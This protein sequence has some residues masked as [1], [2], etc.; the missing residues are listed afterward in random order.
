MLYSKDIFKKN[1]MSLYFLQTNNIVY[2]H[3]EQSFI[4]NLSIIDV[5]MF[6][7]KDE[8]KKILKNF[9]LV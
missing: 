8:M 7:S 3:N 1:K 2:K 5:L 6:N 4:P 9:E